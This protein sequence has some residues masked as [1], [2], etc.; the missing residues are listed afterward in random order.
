MR[1]AGEGATAR[2]LFGMSSAA[3]EEISSCAVESLAQ[4]AAMYRGVYPA[5]QGGQGGR[6]AACAQGRERARRGRQQ[7][8]GAERGG[9]GG[10]GARYGTGI[11]TGLVTQIRNR[12]DARFAYRAVAL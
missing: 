10:A 6:L 12:A 8:Q 7:G 9:R 2:A 5:W 3:P 4:P 1:R 11:G